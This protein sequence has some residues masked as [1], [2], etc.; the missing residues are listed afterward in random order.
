MEKYNN[1]IDKPYVKS[2]K[3]PQMSLNDRAAQFAPFAALTGYEESIQETGRR[4]DSKINLNQDAKQLISSK[5]NYIID[6]KLKELVQITYFVP[7]SKKAGGKYLTINNYIKHID[8]ANK[9][10]YFK[11]NSKITIDKILD[12]H[13]LTI[14]SIFKRLY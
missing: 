3:R 4:T 5:I 1:I 9:I 7:D 2:T 12:I 14:D 11:D 8:S 10:I 13:S 6:H